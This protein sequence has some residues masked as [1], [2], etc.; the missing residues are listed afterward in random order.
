MKPLLPILLTACFCASCSVHPPSHGSDNSVLSD[1]EIYDR[2]KLGMSQSEVEERV[3]KPHAPVSH[4]LALYGGPPKPEWEAPGRAMPFN[5][6]I[7]YS[8]NHTVIYRS[9]LVGP[10]TQWLV[11]GE[12]APHP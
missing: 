5:V 9:L 1:Q 8:T 12:F 11:E 3:G 2:L 7:V 4:G 6:V 10:D